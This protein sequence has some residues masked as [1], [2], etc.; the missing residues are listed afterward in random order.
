[1]D[2]V[3]PQKP[4][5]VITR[6]YT[7]DL[8]EMTTSCWNEVPAERPTVEQVLEVLRI[9]AEEWKSPLSFSP[10]DDASPTLCAEES[11][12]LT[13]SEL[14][15]GHD[16][17]DSSL[18]LDS[19]RS[20]VI[21]TASRKGE[22]EETTPFKSDAVIAKASSPLPVGLGIPPQLPPGDTNHT[23]EPPQIL[24][25]GQRALQRLVSGAAPSGELGSLITAVVPDM[26]TDDIINHLQESNAQM[27]ADVLDQ[28]CMTSFHRQGT[29]SLVTP[30][31]LG[32][33]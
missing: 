12:S 10:Q 5:F 19:L 22:I 14:D 17:T 1:M 23:A 33:R 27:L 29:G 16:T 20:P 28:V 15:D 8:W 32:A 18:P 2:G 31:H 21:K 9:S 30:L 3:R 4:I 26:K 24:S 25:S 11:D 6:G 7:E 13:L